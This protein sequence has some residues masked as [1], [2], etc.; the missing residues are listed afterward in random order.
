MDTKAHW[1]QVYRT[2]AADDVSWYQTHPELSLAFIQA[3]QVALNASI[4]D[5]GAGASTLVDDLLEAGYTDITLLDIAQE[6]LEVARTR[7]HAAASRLT[8][9]IGDITTIPL[10]RHRYDVWHDRAVFHFLTDP[11]QQKGYIDQVLHAIKPGGHIIVATFAPDGPEKCSGLA[12]ARY[13][14]TALHGVFG[15]Q[16]SLIDSTQ[17]SHHT[18]WGTEQRFVYC[19][20]RKTVS[21]A[22]MSIHESA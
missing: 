12:T 6:A 17:E 14:A 20:C 8:W 19:Y 3:T 16:F 1:S 18:P 15:S 9:L 4:I 21:D 11:L 10:A 13:D 7:V 5:V 2:K 22:S